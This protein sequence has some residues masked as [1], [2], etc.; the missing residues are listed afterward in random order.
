MAKANTHG[1]KDIDSM[2]KVELRELPVTN[3]ALLDSGTDV[4]GVAF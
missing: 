2:T 4:L 3:G 1:S